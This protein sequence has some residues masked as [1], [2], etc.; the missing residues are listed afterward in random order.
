MQI[1]TQ[2]NDNSSH[3][4]REN[5]VQKVSETSDARQNEGATDVSGEL[6][7]QVSSHGS[8][9]HKKHY[10]WSLCSID[11][12]KSN[13]SFLIKYLL[14]NSLLSTRFRLLLTKCF[15]NRR[16]SLHQE[17][18]TTLFYG[19]QQLVIDSSQRRMEPAHKSL[20]T[21][22]SFIL[23]SLHFHTHQPTNFYIKLYKILL[24]LFYECFN[25]K[26]N[27]HHLLCR[28][29]QQQQ[30]SICDLSTNNKSCGSEDIFLLINDMH[31][32][33]HHQQQHQGKVTK[34]N[35]FF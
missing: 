29:Q 26:T 3:S 34:F 31:G 16:P 10:K 21:D 2:L 33:E 15:R 30:S 1:R 28:Y 20:T 19:V 8:D 27:C 18:S 6:V 9:S 11:K 35:G 22:K 4:T 24:N 23:F 7:H 25:N 14:V 5:V 12:F 13:C 17:H 32:I